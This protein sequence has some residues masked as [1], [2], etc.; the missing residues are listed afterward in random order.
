MAGNCEIY[1]RQQR[2]IETSDFTIGNWLR[3]G[4]LEPQDFNDD[5]SG[6][7]WRQFPVKSPTQ[8]V[9]FDITAL[10]MHLR[11][12]QIVELGSARGEICPSN[13]FRGPN[14][15]IAPPPIRPKSFRDLY[16][17]GGFTGFQAFRLTT[18]CDRM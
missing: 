4:D 5:S 12:T 7:K 11:R 13:R 10:Q 15:A 16:T 1:L 6:I 14:F 8:I 18:H 17:L 3:D 9:R 2:W